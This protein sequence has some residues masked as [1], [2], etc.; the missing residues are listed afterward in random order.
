MV[1]L[2]DVNSFPVEQSLGHGVHFVAVVFDQFTSQ[3]ILLINDFAH[4]HI[5]LLHGLLRDVGGFG[6][7]AAQEHF[8]FILCI[9][10]G[11]ERFAHA[12]F[13]DHVAGQIGGALE[14]VARAGGHLLHEHFFG[15][16][17]TK[18]HGNL[19]EHKFFVVAVTVLRRQA[20]RHAERTATRDDRHL[21]H[22]ITLGQQAA[23]QRM[24]TLVICGVAA[25]FL[26]HDHALALWTHEDFVFGFFEVL[27]FDHAGIAA[28]G[29][30]RSFVAQVGQISATHAG[31]AAGD[32]AGVHI[33][34]HRDFAHV[35]VENLFTA[36][37]IGQ[38]HI[39]LTVEAA[40][41]QQSCIQNIRAVGGRHHDHA[42]V[43]FK[44]IHL[45]QHLVE[46]LLA[47][48]IATAQARAAL[49]AYGINLVDENNARRIFLGVF[50][51]VAHP[52]CAH[53]HEHFHEI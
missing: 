50:K 46:R 23:N 35:H 32:D 2:H 25:L 22:R 24:A 52:R 29:H 38:G 26:G 1:E 6:H 43:G 48:I 9:D 16:S 41:A 10:H 51:H 20:H 21:V 15:N 3:S 11:A 18:Q 47:L 14:V 34:A 53:A 30:Q 33:L 44:A 13:H 28:R 37:D 8:A 42:E 31:R 7:A 4:L 36:S 17:A 27:H 39:H 45:H 5:H 49:A 40:W 12:V 19:I